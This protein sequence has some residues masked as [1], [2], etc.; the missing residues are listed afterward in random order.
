[1]ILK[2]PGSASAR[3]AEEMVEGWL[4][5][6]DLVKEDVQAGLVKDFGMFAGGMGGHFIREGTSEAELFIDLFKKMDTPGEL[7]S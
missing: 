2:K 6:L 3:S 4:L 7:R 5:E 1:M